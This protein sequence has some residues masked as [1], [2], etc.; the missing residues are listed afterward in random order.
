MC[1]SLEG[2]WRGRGEGFCGVVVRDC[3]GQRYRTEIVIGDALKEQA[4]DKQFP[5][6]L[7]ELP[8]PLW[9]AWD[10]IVCSISD[11]V[12]EI[13]NEM[14][15]SLQVPVWEYCPSSTLGWSAH[16]FWAFSM[17]KNVPQEHGEEKVGSRYGQKAALGWSVM[18]HGLCS[19]LSLL[20]HLCP[21]LWGCFRSGKAGVAAES[22]TGFGTWRHCPLIGLKS[23]ILEGDGFAGLIN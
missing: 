20:S 6:L 10:W 5:K 9:M 19:T 12:A 23:V 21:E 14:Q 1:L 2:L 11:A 13:L 8:F 18:S 7:S 17:L 4:W 22:W 16:W 15:G 3:S